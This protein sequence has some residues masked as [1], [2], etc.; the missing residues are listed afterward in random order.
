MAYHLRLLHCQV[1]SDELVKDTVKIANETHFI[2]NLDNK[3]WLAH[4]DEE[5]I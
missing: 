5:K 4:K 1:N 3:K 2:L